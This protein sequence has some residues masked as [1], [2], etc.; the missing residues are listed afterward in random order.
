MPHRAPAFAV[1]V[2][3]S[4][5]GCR[6]QQCDHRFR[7]E[8]D[9][10][11]TP[12]N[13]ANDASIALTA[14]PIRR[15]APFLT[16]ATCSGKEQSTSR[17]YVS[18]SGSRVRV[19]AN[20]VGPRLPGRKTPSSMRQRSVQTPP[21][22]ILDSV[23]RMDARAPPFARE[24]RST[25][26][27]WLDQWARH[28]PCM[29][30]QATLSAHQGCRRDAFA[31]TPNNGDVDGQATIVMKAVYDGDHAPRFEFDPFLH[32]RSTGQ[33]A[34]LVVYAKR[35][36]PR[37]ICLDRRRQLATF[38]RDAGNLRSTSLRLVQSWNAQPSMKRRC[39]R[40]K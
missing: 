22:C 14:P 26:C 20:R 16:I 12:I 25:S 37:S 15:S 1:H 34:Q 9:V 33:L 21:T 27:A 31:F 3:Q 32:A 39:C 18:A 40:W 6:L 2:H 5:P 4:H 19:R 28:G 17:P 10:S 8:W 35:P 29:L 38:R 13:S 24:E 7:T 23:S 11:F 30:T 36:I